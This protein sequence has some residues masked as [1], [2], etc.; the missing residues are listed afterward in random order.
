M[1]LEL[2]LP[3]LENKG[4]EEKTRRSVI[5]EFSSQ[6]TQ[7]GLRFGALSSFPFS[8]VSVWTGT[9]EWKGWGEPI[10]SLGTH[11]VVCQVGGS[12]FIHLFQKQ[13]VVRK[14]EVAGHG[15]EATTG[16]AAI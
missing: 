12:H 3:H 16:G 11:Q 7:T 9:G 6:P 5:P 15:L 1:L 2:Q 4:E 13:R 14:G 10:L 8:A